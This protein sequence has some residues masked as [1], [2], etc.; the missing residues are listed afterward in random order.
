MFS[1]RG[2]GQGIIIS[3]GEPPTLI[4]NRYLMPDA[5][6]LISFSSQRP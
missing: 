3:H 1:Y 2:D 5:V 4:G 6:L